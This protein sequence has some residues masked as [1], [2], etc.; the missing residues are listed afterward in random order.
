MRALCLLVSLGV[1]ACG[2]TPPPAAP[3]LPS[4]PIAEPGAQK[5]PDLSPVEAP[6]GL[7]A[8]ARLRKPEASLKTVG[9]WV[10]LPMPGGELVMELMAGES[11]ANVVD[12]SQPIDLA[13][14]VSTKTPSIRP[15]AAISASVRSMDEAKAALGSRAK[16]EP[17]ENGSFRVSGLG[18]P[19]DDRDEHPCLL[20][21][22]AGP[23]SARLVCADSEQALKM[24]A[25]YLTRTAPNEK[26][27]SDLHVTVR[28]EPVRDTLAQLRSALPMMLGMMGGRGSS[29]GPPALKESIEAAVGDVVDLVSDI[30]TIDLDCDLSDPGASVNATAKFRSNTSLLAKLA[31]SHPERADVPPA[32]FWRLPADTDVAFFHRGVDTKDIDHARQLGEAVLMSAMEEGGMP[33]AERR[34]LADVTSR[35]LMLLANPLVFG[36]GV[37]VAGIQKA[38]LAQKSVK[39]GDTA[40]EEEAR[41]AL[42]E[43][44]GGWYLFA[45][46]EP[47]AKTAQPFKDWVSVWN[48]PKLK[49]FFKEKRGKDAKG[50]DLPQMKLGAPP[51][52][53]PKDTVHVEVSIPTRRAALAKDDKKLPPPKPIVFHA[54]VVPDGTKSWVGFS[55]D[56]ATVAARLQ[57]ALP[58][59]PETGTIGKRAGLDA[60][61]DQKSGAGGF[62]TLRG[63]VT[64]L[65][66]R[67]ALR[68]EGFNDPFKTINDKQGVVPLPFT[69]T[70]QQAGGGG[71]G[72]FVATAKLPKS[73]IEETARFFMREGRF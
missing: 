43:E 42:R 65:P 61:R 51:K 38:Q 58:T 6:K 24:L 53:L 69:L 59:G 25:A 21:P 32:A 23:S 15:M 18:P 41:R 40:A 4:K 62:V 20:A 73:A 13:V 70:A 44:T 72:S 2:G 1:C 64:G 11:L 63:V 35:T 31:T 30:D 46:N 16:Y 60:L 49:E 45:F 56:G 17:S 66:I 9:G 47:L 55:L 71:A 39:P 26:T 48:R 5:P 10:G 67:E 57:A 12:M 34:A 3:Q 68:S 27:S 7:V 8:F 52:G 28:T 29:G 22:S 36:K 14:A 50:V 33:D 19:G 54:I 37:D